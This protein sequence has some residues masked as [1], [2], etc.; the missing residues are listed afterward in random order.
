MSNSKVPLETAAFGK[1]R[2]EPISPILNR[3]CW[4]K[5]SRSARKGSKGVA[6]LRSRDLTT[7]AADFIQPVRAGCLF[8]SSFGFCL[9][10]TLRSWP[11]PKPS[12]LTENTIRQNDSI[13]VK[14]A[15]GSGQR[16]NSRHAEP[17]RPTAHP[18][19]VSSRLHTQRRELLRGVKLLRFGI[20]LCRRAFATP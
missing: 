5:S 20:W 17:A 4:I 10:R 12:I 6:G 14:W 1:P 19:T 13:L 2:L 8:A 9:D 3:F 7:R 18:R 15:L 11:S 16:F